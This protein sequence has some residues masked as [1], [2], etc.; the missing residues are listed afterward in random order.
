MASVWDYERIC[1]KMKINKPIYLVTADIY[2]RFPEIMEEE[3]NDLLE[4]LQDEHIVYSFATSDVL[5]LQNNWNKL[6]ECLREMIN[7]IK[8]N[9]VY[10]RTEY[11]CTQIA[12]LESTL[13]KMQEIE[14]GVNND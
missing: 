7:E 6:K 1:L 4:Y 12:T 8:T 5:K 9:D 10:D 14:G 13:A 3:Y 11:E 2:L